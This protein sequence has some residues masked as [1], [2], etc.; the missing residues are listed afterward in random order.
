MRRGHVKKTAM[1][2]IMKISDTKKNKQLK[3][4]KVLVKAVPILT[5]SFS[6]SPYDKFV[7]SE[8]SAH[9]KNSHYFNK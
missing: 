6:V 3:G 7:R 2:Y 9:S 4:F 5:P 8:I 1:V